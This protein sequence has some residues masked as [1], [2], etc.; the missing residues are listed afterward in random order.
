[1]DLWA[2]VGSHILPSGPPVLNLGPPLKR[3]P[4]LP[5]GSPSLRPLRG[6]VGGGRS[7]RVREIK[8]SIFLPLGPPWVGRDW[9]SGLRPFQIA[10]FWTHIDGG[11]WPR[12]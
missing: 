5:Q 12:G 2:V 10:L 4:D 3:P 8:K 7:E 6:R 9:V 11:L 1:M